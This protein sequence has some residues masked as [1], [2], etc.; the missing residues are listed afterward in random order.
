MQDTLSVGS[1]INFGWE[2]FKK[3]PWF[4]IG[5]TIVYVVA[6]WCISFVSSF[7]GGFLAVFLGSGIAGLSSFVVSTALGM[8][9]AMGWL[10][11]LIKVH[12][13]PASAALSSLWHPQKFWSYLGTTILLFIIVAGGFI[14]FIIPGFMALTAFFFA[15]YFV[16]DKG[17]S[18][19]EA[20]KASARITKGNRMRVLALIAAV[21][22][23]SLLGVVALIVGLLVVIPFTA[24]ANMHAYRRLSAAADANETRQPLSA[25]EI[26][27]AIVGAVIPVVIVVVGILS[28]VLLA[29]LSVAQ[30]KGREALA[31][32][33]LKS[34]QLSLEVYAI[35][36]NDS[37]PATLSDMSADP[38]TAVMMSSIPLN[39]FS[40]AWL[41]NGKAYQL[42]SDKP[43]SGGDQCVSSEDAPST[44]P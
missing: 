27:L 40:Y 7:V 43:V 9:I 21:A 13:D 44:A 38:Q 18:P 25:G 17:L 36:H 22:L 32:A 3:R 1:F 15:P 5:A 12:D 16:I 30:E 29:S 23:L 4:L 14:L 41:E 8:L 26:V 31:G 10:A 2:T 20:L 28:A 39:E 33:N 37:Y 6:S 19:I 34:L 35:E 42:C 11:F 24:V